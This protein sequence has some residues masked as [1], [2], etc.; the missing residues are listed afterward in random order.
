MFQA[1]ERIAYLSKVA[2]E[3]PELR[4][5]DLYNIIKRPEFLLHAYYQIA[6]NKGSKTAGIDK[7]TRSELEGNLGRTI[8]GLSQELHDQNYTP[9][10]VRRVE[11]PKSSGGKRP[12]GIP[13]LKDRIVQ[14]A[15][16]LL[17]EAIYESKFSDSSH[18]F[19]PKRSCQTAINYITVKKYDWVIEGDIKGCFDNINHGKLLEILRYR[20]ADEK[21]INLI[22]K[23]LKSGYQL[24]YGI[25]GK[26]PVFVTK[27][28]T[29]QG[30][31]VS[32]ILA[33][34][35]LNEFD[36]YIEPKLLNFPED[37]YKLKSSEYTYYTNRLREIRKAIQ[38]NKFPLT[39]S[40]R[41]LEEEYN[42]N[43]TY[44]ENSLELEDILL[45][46]L[47]ER[48]KYSSKEIEY[49]T[50]NSRVLRLRKYLK[51]DNYPIRIFS[52]GRPKGSK[53]KINNREEAVKKI[54]DLKKDRNKSSFYDKEKYFQTKT[55]G[56]VRYADDFVILMGNYNKKAAIE[57]KAEISEWFTESLNL[58]LSEE[59]T[60]ITHSTN[61]FTFL[62]YDIIKRPNE[63]D[64]IGY[65]DT[66]SRIYVPNSRIKRAKERIDFLIQ[67]H[68]NSPP[69]DLIINL[70]RF[71]SGWSNYY[72]IANNWHTIASKLYSYLYW[73]VLHWLG[74]KYKCSIPQVCRKHVK[75]IVAFGNNWK[76]IVDYVEGKPI[77]LK[78]FRDYKYTTPYEIATKIMSSNSG[79]T[80]YQGTGEHYDILTASIIWSG[81]SPTHR[82]Q[83]EETQGA[84]C[85]E[86]GDKEGPFEV[87]HIRK[88]NR[89]RK[90]R[91]LDIIKAS[92]DIPKMLL[93]VPCH[94]KVPTT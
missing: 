32:P 85:C 57:L 55:L 36:K 69:S 90:K 33:N 50:L 47:D 7:I 19:R 42:T 72:K 35:Y 71:T 91:V 6:R 80:G 11:I 20:I 14:S 21:L 15:V 24:G 28:G 48:K 54:R 59:K 68:F 46:T 17:L 18:G 5:K 81:G 1:T 61:G 58:T 37:E 2:K 43:S 88:V 34:I 62:G 84:I 10:A 13:A 86:C 51:E 73:K 94:N 22:N 53:V 65:R 89:N 16:K 27:Q 4:F 66:F 45:K 8:Q 78:Q 12:L 67:T 39:I 92:N 41:N 83:L 9:L 25:E 74:R 40:E 87:H 29:P 76:R 79:I 75:S 23:F 3:K 44:I 93:C 63:K 26:L 77:V 56:Y 31:I 64:R 49:K 60:K 38:N 82:I 52:N 30:G 70:N